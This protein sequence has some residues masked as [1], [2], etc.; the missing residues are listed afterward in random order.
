MPVHLDSVSIGRDKI[1]VE[2]SKALARQLRHRKVRPGTNRV[3][4]SFDPEKDLAPIVPQKLAQKWATSKGAAGQ[5]SPVT[6]LTSIL[7]SLLPGQAA[8]FPAHKFFHSSYSSMLAFQQ[9]AYQ[10]ISLWIKS[11]DRKLDVHLTNSSQQQQIKR[12]LVPVLLSFLSRQVDT[13]CSSVLF[14]DIWSLLVI[15]T[16]VSECQG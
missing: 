2:K 5:C 14:L 13:I 15:C 7:A 3:G 16:C 12:F 1:V 8:Q 4:D 6:I 9:K 11:Q 10:L